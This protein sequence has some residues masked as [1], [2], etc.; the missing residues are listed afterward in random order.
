MIL[1]IIIVHCQSVWLGPSPFSLYSSGSDR[2]WYEVFFT[3]PLLLTN[4]SFPC[5]RKSIAKGDW[6][7]TSCLFL[8]NLQYWRVTSLIKHCDWMAR[9]QY[10][11]DPA[12]HQG[13]P[14]LDPGF[15]VRVCLGS[16]TSYFLKICVHLGFT[17]CPLGVYFGSSW[18]LLSF[19]SVCFWG[20]F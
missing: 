4:Q 15:T 3:R 2:H 14:Q 12:W 1:T 5:F 7:N 13:G 17:L 16:T 8:C 18:G 10:R 11:S 9:V 6:K 19:Y 20:P